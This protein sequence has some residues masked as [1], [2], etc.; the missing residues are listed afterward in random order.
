MVTWAAAVRVHLGHRAAMDRGRLVVVVVAGDVVGH[1]RERRHRR[2]EGVLDDQ[3]A[4]EE[5]VDQLV[6]LEF[7]E[8]RVE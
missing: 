3:V 7:L 8:T 2:A 6:G 1:C 4:M 5:A